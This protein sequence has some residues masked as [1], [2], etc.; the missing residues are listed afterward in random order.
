MQ[1]KCDLSKSVDD[2][3]LY[4]RC[5]RKALQR[6]SPLRGMPFDGSRVCVFFFFYICACCIW[7]SLLSRDDA[8][9]S[10][11]GEPNR[12]PRQHWNRRCH[13]ATRNN[14]LPW[15]TFF[16]D[17]S[18]GVDHLRRPR[19]RRRR[20]APHSLFVQISLHITSN[21]LHDNFT[22]AFWEAASLSSLSAGAN[23][24]SGK[25]LFTYVPARPPVAM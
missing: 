25:Q 15:R 20:R 13:P 2:V 3:K 23:E 17:S 21:T 5:L 11:G 6:T 8:A 4:W 1:L 9:S 12:K 10:P 24:A 16:I 14:W 22:V 19:R 7:T 18:S